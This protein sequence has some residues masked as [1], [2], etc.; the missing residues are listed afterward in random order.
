[1]E[2]NIKENL[3]ENKPKECVPYEQC[4]KVKELATAYVPYQKLCSI[5]GLD[6]AMVKGTIFPELAS[7]YCKIDKEIMRNNNNC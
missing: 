3:K 1:M 5:Y 7:S 6:E 2:E 4:I